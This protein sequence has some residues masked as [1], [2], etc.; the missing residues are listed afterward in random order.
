MRFQAGAIRTANNSRQSSAH[1]VRSAFQKLRV[2]LVA[3]SSFPRGRGS[4]SKKR[5]PGGNHL[6]ARIERVSRLVS[7]FSGKV[8]PGTARPVDGGTRSEVDR[9]PNLDG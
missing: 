5:S 6:Y 1:G 7:A 8:W 4:S 3:A 9:C 2:R